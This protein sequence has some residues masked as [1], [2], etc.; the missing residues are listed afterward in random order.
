MKAILQTENGRPVAEIEIPYSH[1]KLP[2]VLLQGDRAFVFHE[3]MGYPG[4]TA[5]YRENT[6]HVIGNLFLEVKLVYQGKE[7]EYT[8]RG[9]YTGDPGIYDELRVGIFNPQKE[10]VGDAL[11]TLTEEGEPQAYLTTA[12]DGDG[13]HSLSWFPLRE[14][15]KAVGNHE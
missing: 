15:E 12:G 9:E 14:T 6:I 2:G 1:D 4:G 5:Y 13:D 10:C 11:F 3:L 7:G 8:A